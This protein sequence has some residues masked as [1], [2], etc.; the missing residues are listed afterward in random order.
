MKSEILPLCPLEFTAHQNSHSLNSYKL[1]LLIQIESAALLNCGC[2][3][4]FPLGLEG[5]FNQSPDFE[6]HLG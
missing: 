2:F 6:S 4:S 5:D 3:S 1:C